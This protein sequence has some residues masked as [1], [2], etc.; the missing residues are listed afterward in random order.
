[1]FVP[2]VCF[3]ALT[4][5]IFLFVYLERFDTIFMSSLLNVIF[6]LY[7]N[8]SLQLIKS[9]ESGHIVIDP[10]ELHIY[11]QIYCY[12]PH[13]LLTQNDAFACSR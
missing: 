10:D 2:L 8:H 13:N 12:F 7:S 6:C 5:F 3:Y 9:P 1:M 4:R 11:H